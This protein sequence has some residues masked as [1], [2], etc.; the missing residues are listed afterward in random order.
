MT[1]RELAERFA[2]NPAWQLVVGGLV[3]ALAFPGR[4][5]G[6]VGT[7]AVVGAAGLGAAWLWQRV[8]A[9]MAM[10][11]PRIGTALVVAFV[12]MLGLDTFWDALTVSPDWQM[13]DWGP[14]HAVLARAMHALPG[15]DLPTWNHVVSTG[16][17]PFELYPKLT[18][19][20]TGHVALALG[21]EDDLPQAFMIV[22]VLVHLGICIMTTVIATRVAPRPIA[23]VVGAMCVVESGA[24]SEGGPIDIFRWALLH[25]A[26]SLVFALVAV[27]GVLALLTRARARAAI[28]IWLGTALATIAHPVGL[29]TALGTV[30][31][32]LAVALL[33]HDVPPRRA[34][35]ALGHVVLGVALGAC[36]WM[37]LT[38]RILLYGQ[39]FPVRVF[40]AAD[41]LE[42][43]LRQAWPTSRFA[44]M[45]YAGLL[46][47][48]MMLWSRR[49][50][51]VFLA[52][53]TLVF[54]V[55]VSDAPVMALDLAPGFGSSRLGSVRLL[56]L[57]RP[58]VAA[59]AA[60][61]FWVV[62]AAAIR[63]WRAAPPSR[64]TIGLAIAAILTG[65]LV[66][67]LPGLW[68]TVSTQ[69]FNTTRELAPDPE[70]RARLTDWGRARAA[71]LRPDAWGRALF[72][73][74]THE[75]FH[76]TALTGLP[77]F[78]LPAQPDLLLRERI[79]DTSAESLRRFNVRWVIAQGNSP[80]L[81][82]PATEIELGTYRVREVADW[83]GQFAR[84][85]S[86]TGTVRTTRL[87]DAAVVIEVSGSEPVLVAL[88]TGYYP[89]WRAMT[90][91]GAVP[92]YAMPATPDGKLHVVA[93]WVPPGTTTFTCDGSLPSDGKGTVFSLLALVGAIAGLVA[94]RRWRQRLLRKLAGRRLPWAWITRAAVP[95]GFGVLA[96]KGCL[97]AH[98]PLPA[99]ELGAGLRGTAT[100]EARL[101]EGPW[102]VCSYSRIAATYECPQ[103]LVV[104]DELVSLVNDAPPS[105]SFTTPGIIATA[106]VPGVEMRI[107]IQGRLAGRYLVGT[108]G[109][110]AKLYVDDD[111]PNELRRATIDFADTGVRAIRVRAAVPTSGWKF[112]LVR[113][114]LIQ[115][116]RPFL[117]PPPASPPADVR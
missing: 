27:L 46:G 55:G 108:S 6:S 49:A 11:S 84:V 21:L 42:T 85:Q 94:W 30:I 64:R 96:I 38:E 99:F 57:A 100:V 72:E 24:V 12:A 58:L 54:L 73:T 39:H 68:R 107:R 70:G 47:I 102:Q 35:V 1:A 80:E 18:Y 76:L 61:A 92:V 43:I 89:R 8:P 3:L 69:A 14:Q 20:V 4:L 97:D 36:V 19:L 23:L 44:L 32:L 87:D 25:S 77:S 53:A 88:G 26:L 60:Y 98:A 74:D 101:D 34:L 67:E 10:V 9:R 111:T 103:L 41:V 75:H 51:L 91:K 117:V 31:A 116:R 104:R 95:L 29:V 62:I 81:G 115:P 52:A 7:M 17:A 112:T 83:D 66:R 114:E 45:F 50:P 63:G 59:C 82:D 2:R 106:H 5:A 79:E 48:V 78:H 86:G 22:A 28:V 109:G 113:E 16:D 90:A 110:S 33:A 56:S 105:W 15:L 93:A 13:G 40:P 71:E 37:P 65:G